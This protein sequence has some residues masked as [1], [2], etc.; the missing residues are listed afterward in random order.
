MD[1]MARAHPRLGAAERRMKVYPVVQDFIYREPG[2]DAAVEDRPSAR[3]KGGADEYR[4]QRRQPCAKREDRARVAMVNVMDRSH[5]S[6]EPM[7]HPAVD[8]ILKKGPAKESRAEK[9][10]ESENP[11]ST[12]RRGHINIVEPRTTPAQS[13]CADGIRLRE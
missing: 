9:S 7:A 1:Q 13:A 5:E 12:N 4:H 3:S 10:G 11:G 8:R 6:R 2:Q